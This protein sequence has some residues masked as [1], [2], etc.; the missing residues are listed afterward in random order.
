MVAFA[1]SLRTQTAAGQVV[2]ASSQHA[3]RYR[4]KKK[5]MKETEKKPRRAWFNMS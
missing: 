5:E 4:Q 1:K 3:G 2:G